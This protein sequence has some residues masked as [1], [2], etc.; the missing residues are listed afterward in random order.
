MNE[1]GFSAATAGLGLLLLQLLAMFVFVPASVFEQVH[2]LE[3][4]WFEAVRSDQAVIRVADRTFDWYVSI[5]D[6][7]GISDG[8]R[9]MFVPEEGARERSGAMDNLGSSF[10]FP[11]VE[12]RG[13]AANAITHLLLFRVSALISWFPFILAIIIPAAIDG[14]MERRVKQNTFSYPSVLQHRY[15]GIFS[16][17]VMYFTLAVFLSPLPVPPP[18]VP[19]GIAIAF[20]TASILVVGNMPKRI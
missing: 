18:L 19:A 4:R 12:S 7:S 3:I 14:V 8:L 9:W 6:E 11:Y 20:A 10:W 16:L 2:K 13:E 17:L 5:V 1:R 15:G